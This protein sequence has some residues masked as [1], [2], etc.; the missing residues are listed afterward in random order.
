MLKSAT[1]ALFLLFI[2]G[3]AGTAPLSSPVSSSEKS[4]FT[5]TEGCFLLYNMKTGTFDKVINEQRCQERLPACSTF[6]VPLAVMAFDAKILKDQNTKLKGK[7]HTAQ[8]WMRE[9]V[10]WYSQQI[11]PKLGRKKFQKYLNDFNYGN[12]D[13]SAGITQAWLEAPDKKSALKI[14]AYEQVDFMKALWQS[15]LP[16]SEQ[17][18]Q[19]TRELTYLETS[20]Q[21]FK[22]NGKTGSNFYDK[23]HTVHLGWF[24]AHIQKGDQEYI[25]ITNLKDLTPNKVGNYGGPRAKALTKEILT[26]QGLW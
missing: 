10:V 14:S 4:F 26:A 16:V 8:T 6:K 5:D 11:T 2:L 13:L 3:C 1:M 12:K 9:S 19:L 15:K 17:A 24:I 7:E 25:A 18:M 21:G 20:P 23:E 22:L